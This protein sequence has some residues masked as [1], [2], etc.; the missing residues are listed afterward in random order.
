MIYF[1]YSRIQPRIFCIF[2][3]ELHKC[4]KR[5]KQF[6]CKKVG[7]CGTYFSSQ[8]CKKS[9]DFCH[10]WSV[11]LL[12]PADLKEESFITS[13]YRSEIIDFFVFTFILGL[14]PALSMQFVF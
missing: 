13:T 10:I 1:V 2:N 14:F 12:H 11:F 5:I 8:N 4:Q 6:D 7:T 3:N 9:S